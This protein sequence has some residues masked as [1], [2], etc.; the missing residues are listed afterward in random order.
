MES[1]GPQK[2]PS[3]LS[4]ATDR[5]RRTEPRLSAEILGLDVD[6]SLSQGVYVRVLNVS[7]GGALVELHEWLRPGTKSALK[8]SRPA[9]DAGQRDRLT[10]TG[11]IVRCW[12]DRLAPLRYRAAIVFT[13]A[14]AA[15]PPPTPPTDLTLLLE[16]PA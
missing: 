5:D 15:A 16:R 3:P 7:Q 14:P 10:A 8:L 4:I 13:G 6:A 12:V 9:E 2:P 1:S 11:H